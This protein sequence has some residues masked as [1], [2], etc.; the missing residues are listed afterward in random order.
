MSKIDAGAVKLTPKESE[1]LIAMASKPRQE[2]SFLLDRPNARTVNALV[3]KGMATDIMGTFWRITPA[4]QQRVA[5]L[6][7]SSAA[8]A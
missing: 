7:Q 5:L 3:R 6:I 4:G 1:M 8:G 2:L